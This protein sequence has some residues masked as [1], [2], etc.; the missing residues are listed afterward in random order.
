M[1]TKPIVE[2]L[3]KAKINRK[4]NYYE[5]LQLNSTTSFD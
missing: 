1:K 5:Y 4:Q 3:N 2:K